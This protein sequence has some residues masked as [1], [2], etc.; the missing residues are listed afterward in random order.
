ME[1]V[2]HVIQ[3]LTKDQL[4][5]CLRAHAASI[6]VAGG[7]AGQT[8]G[9]FRPNR[10]IITSSYL[11]RLLADGAWGQPSPKHTCVMSRAA[12]AHQAASIRHQSPVT[13]QW[14]LVTCQPSHVT[15][16]PSYFARY[17]LLVTSPPAVTSYSSHV[18]HHGSLITFLYYIGR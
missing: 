15:H 18:I 8:I 16:H 2:E 3:V 13:R 4:L 14:V 5:T 7:R 17:P 1:E 9:A 10:R 11:P 12:Y 6:C